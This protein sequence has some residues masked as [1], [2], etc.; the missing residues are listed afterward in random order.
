MT[1]AD[2]KTGDGLRLQ[3]MFDD[4]GINRTEFAKKMNVA[5]ATIALWYSKHTL[6]VEKLIR[7]EK[8]LGIDI[9]NYFPILL[10]HDEREKILDKSYRHQN[11]RDKTVKI[12]KDEYT[13]YQML[14][15][16]TLHLEDMIK[17]KDTLITTLQENI[18]L[19]KSK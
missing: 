14:K 15:Q 16:K 18:M 8:T 17:Q 11:G 4:L 19:L 10:E 7:I 1:T 13:E 9:S 12:T 2:N 6:P 5:R 3:M